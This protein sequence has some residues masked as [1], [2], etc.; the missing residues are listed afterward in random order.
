MCQ[1]LEGE[2]AMHA[3]DDVRGSAS[4]DAVSP[5]LR[6]EESLGYQVNLAARLFARA[7]AALVE[8]LGLAPGQFPVLLALWEREERTQGELSR[9]V[10]VEQPTMANTL[11]RMERDGLIQRKPDPRDRRRTVIRLT[12][13]GRDLES[14]AVAA[15]RS[16]NARAVQGLT[17]REQDELRRMLGIVA[18]NLGLHPDNATTQE[19]TP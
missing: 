1:K 2:S 8:P 13:R 6:A 17:P 16:I 5:R 12:T 10:Q 9:L 11:A 18:A 7:L 4:Q 14:P 19:E 3:S 15:A